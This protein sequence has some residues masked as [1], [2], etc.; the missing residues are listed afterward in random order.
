MKNALS[1]EPLNQA[2]SLVLE[3]VK[4]HNSE[5]DLEELRELLLDFSYRKM[6]Q[7][8]DEVIAQK[9]YTAADFEKMLKGHDRKAR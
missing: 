8:L 3:V 9:G 6:Q 2:Q 7:H 5:Q 1:A 4:N